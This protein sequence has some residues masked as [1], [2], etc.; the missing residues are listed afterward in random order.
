MWL[1]ILVTLAVSSLTFAM[2]SIT[3]QFQSITLEA[4]FSLNADLLLLEKDLSFSP[5]GKGVLFCSMFC[6]EEPGELS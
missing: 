3:K 6:A 1:L 2:D 4:G 5:P